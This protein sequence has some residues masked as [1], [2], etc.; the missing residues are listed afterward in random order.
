MIRWLAPKV[1]AD[2]YHRHVGDWPDVRETPWLQWTASPPAIADLDR[3]GR[4]R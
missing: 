1:E 4:T 2:H 3:D